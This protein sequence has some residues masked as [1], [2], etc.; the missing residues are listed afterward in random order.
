MHKRISIKI[1]D[2]I[3]TF[4]L[5][6]I[7]FPVVPIALHITSITTIEIKLWNIAVLPASFH[8]VIINLNAASTIINLEALVIQIAP[9]VT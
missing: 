9:N 3:A 2:Y 8:I 4:Y 1:I 7:I 6:G 5:P